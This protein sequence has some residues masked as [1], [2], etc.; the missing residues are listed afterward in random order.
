MTRFLV[1]SI[2]TPGPWF[3]ATGEGVTLCEIDE[4]SGEIRRVRAYP[5]FDNAMWMA[6]GGRFTFVATERFLDGGEIVVFDPTMA[7]TGPAQRTPGGAICHLA[8]SPDGKALYTVSYLGGVTVHLID[9]AGVIAPAHQEIAYIG[10]GA[11]PERQEKSHPHQAVVS[12]DGKHLFVCDLGSDKVWVHPIE[13]GGKLG[14]PGAID[15]AAGSGPRHLVFHPHLPRLYLLGE[16]DAVVRVYEGS[17]ADW[18]LVD[19]HT[20]IPENFTGTPGGGAIR[21]HPSGKTLAVSVRGSDTLAVFHLDARGDLTP[22]ANFPTGGKTPRDFDFTPSGRRLLALNQ[23]SDN[24]VA[25]GFDS[26]TGLPT[27]DAGTPF[28][29]GCPMCVIF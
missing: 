13:D 28:A 21:L 11:N 23:D 26:A 24:L 15:A 3:H 1:G 10:S 22:A 8:L 18:K 19:S 7:S 29:L 17:G 20:A 6:R 25:F 9:D 12:P 5:E 4:A 27:G 2:N 16:L 14:L